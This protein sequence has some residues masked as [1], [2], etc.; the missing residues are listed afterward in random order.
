MKNE[1]LIQLRPGEQ[2]LDVVREDFVPTLPW[3]IFLFIWIAL[4]FFFLVP[5]MRQGMI[6]LIFLAV[7]AGAGVIMTFR[8]H[9][10]WQKTVLVVT[11][12]RSVDISQHGFFDRTVN[13]LE[14]KDLSEV[15]FR[16]KGLLSTTFRF[17]T[18]YLRA[19][20]NAADI[21]VRRIHRPID[22]H[23]LLNDLKKEAKNDS[24]AVGR[25]QKLK[26][27]ANHLSDDEVIRLAAAVEKRERDIASQQFFQK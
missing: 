13:E 19:A 21:A 10:S 2:I 9:F 5:L 12:Q 20:G 4:P 16:V 22:L 26:S 25:V 8:T 24:L 15:T 17:G 7:M 18:V 23:H 11:D 3:W 27:L 14:H 1:N 6:G